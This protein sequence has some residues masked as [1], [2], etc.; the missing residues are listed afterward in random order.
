MSTLQLEENLESVRLNLPREVYENV[1]MN[2]TNNNN[3][4]IFPIQDDYIIEIW[5]VESKV[6]AYKIDDLDSVDQITINTS[7]DSKYLFFT[8]DQNEIS[9]MD[10]LQHRVV[11]KYVGTHK[12][13]ITTLSVTPDATRLFSAGMEGELCFY[14]VPTIKKGD[15]VHV[16]KHYGELPEIND[17]YWMGINM[18]G[19]EGNS[20]CVIQSL[21]NDVYVID[22]IQCKVISEVHIP[23]SI[24]GVC[25]IA[26]TLDNSRM[27]LTGSDSTNIVEIDIAKMSEKSNDSVHPSI[28]SHSS[29]HSGGAPWG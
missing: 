26:I 25:D 4:I 23:M 21:A 1:D 27:F 12:G 20:K 13:S 28:K 7:P 5:D 17:N 10:I 3:F 11:A 15:P 18:Q 29:N 24:Q 22:I 2:I 16:I 19:E 8:S 9:Q 6:L 14:Q